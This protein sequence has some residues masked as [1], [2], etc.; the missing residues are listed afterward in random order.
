MRMAI[1][2]M[3]RPRGM[4]HT[5]TDGVAEVS[6]Y[7]FDAAGRLVT[8]WLQ[9]SGSVAGHILNYGYASTGGCGANAAAGANGNRTSFTDQRVDASWALLSTSSVAYCY[10]NAD[11][12]TSTTPVNPQV[13]AAPVA[14]ASLALGTTLAYDSHGNTTVLADQAMT[15]DISDQHVSTTV[16]G[17]TVTYDRNVSGAIVQRSS[18]DDPFATVRYTSGAVLNAAGAIIQRTVSLPGGVSVTLTP[19]GP[20]PDVQ[21]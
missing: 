10:D 17:E 4:P 1:G 15:Y 20:D 12:L 9:A 19:A 16:G 18:T 7:K 5:L 11:R 13:G 3:M 2:P 8:A 6:T 21:A 14:A